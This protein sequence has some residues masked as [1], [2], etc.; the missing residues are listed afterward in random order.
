[1][2]SAAHYRGLA[3][4]PVASVPPNVEFFVDD[5]EAEWTFTKPF[6]FIY[7]R[8]LSGSIRDWPKL[9]GQAFR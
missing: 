1:M 9:L 3:A 5:L 4:D 2:S 7:M 6:D 8:M